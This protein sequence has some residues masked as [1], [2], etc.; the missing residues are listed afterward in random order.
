MPIA[1]L[2]GYV[3]D[4]EELKQGPVDAVRQ[5]PL[6]LQGLRGLLAELL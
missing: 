1:M 2:A 4:S 3:S 6:D 5:K